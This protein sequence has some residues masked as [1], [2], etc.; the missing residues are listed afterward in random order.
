MLSNEQKS[1][2]I[3]SHIKNLAYNKYNFELSLIEENSLTNKNQG[4][5][6]SITEQI[7]FIDAKIAALETEK[8]SLTE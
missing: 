5:I 3:D 1:E 2:L 6:D 4:A 7:S 8:A